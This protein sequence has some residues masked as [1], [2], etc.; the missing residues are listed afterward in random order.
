[1]LGRARHLAGTGSIAGKLE[2]LSRSSASH[3]P[4]SFSRTR[5]SVL[6]GT[7]LGAAEVTAA[8]LGVSGLPDLGNANEG[9]NNRQLVTK[10][11]TRPTVTH[12]WI[13]AR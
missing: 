1:M 6:P 7:Q 10:Q 13:R 9:Q 8:C 5:E 11:S 4:P 2:V 12:V 3:L